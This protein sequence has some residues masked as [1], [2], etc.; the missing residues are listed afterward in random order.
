MRR[1]QTKASC[2]GPICSAISRRPGKW[3]STDGKPKPYATAVVNE[4]QVPELAVDV[5]RF[6]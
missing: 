4:S 3:L 2:T 1:L 6:R 5:L